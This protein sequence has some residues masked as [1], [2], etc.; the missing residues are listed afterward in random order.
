MN[1]EVLEYEIE[2]AKN[3]LVAWSE[4]VEAR[5][6]VFYWWTV[7]PDD[8]GH[9]CFCLQRVG[10]TYPQ[11]LIEVHFG[12]YGKSDVFAIWK[13]FTKESEKGWTDNS[14]PIIIPIA[15]RSLTGFQHVATKV[16]WFLFNRRFIHTSEAE[17][18]LEEARVIQ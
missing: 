3:I 14:I 9:R 16:Q 6:K 15:I 17:K 4:K 2:T 8:D 13:V 5:C 18:L 12:P 10:Q 1:E 7:R 11:G